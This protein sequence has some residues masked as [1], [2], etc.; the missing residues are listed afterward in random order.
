VHLDDR[1][2]QHHGELYLAEV[3]GTLDAFSDAIADVSLY[4]WNRAGGDVALVT[5]AERLD[6]V[7][8][9]KRLLVGAFR[10]RELT[11]AR[12]LPTIHIL[13]SAY[14]R[15]GWDITRA[16]RA[17]DL[18]DFGHAAAALAYCHCFATERSLAELIR[19]SGLDTLYDITVVTDCGAL[20]Q[21]LTSNAE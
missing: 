6:S 18:A 16:Y 7:E 8:H 1:R 12:R 19:Q 20:R 4:L 5:D 14:A 21:W 2:S 10:E 3:R 17:N 13:A 11:T 9:W 15:V